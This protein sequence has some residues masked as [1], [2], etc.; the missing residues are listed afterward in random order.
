METSGQPQAPFVSLWNSPVAA[1]GMQLDA[2]QEPIKTK[3]KI[4]FT[5]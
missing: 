2:P 1:T 4:G 3:K 5:F